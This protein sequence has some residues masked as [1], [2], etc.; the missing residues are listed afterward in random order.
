LF[1][2]D[3][4]WRDHVALDWDLHTLHGLP[5]IISFLSHRLPSLQLGSFKVVTEGQFGP[6][7]SSPIDGLEWIESM[8]T[9]ET[10]IGRGRGMLRLAGASDGS[11]KAHIMY[12][13]LEELKGFEELT[14]AR[15]SQGSKNSLAGGVIKGNWFERRQRTFDFVDEDPQALIIGAGKI[16]FAS[17]HNDMTH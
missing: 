9:F 4:W 16:L 8:F 11:H 1:H 3:S 10:A 7:I 15:R 12:T 2:D 14:G 13:A 17:S 5:K 6:S